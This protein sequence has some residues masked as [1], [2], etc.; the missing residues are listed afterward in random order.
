MLWQIMLPYMIHDL[1]YVYHFQPYSSRIWHV[2]CHTGRQSSQSRFGCQDGSD[3]QHGTAVRFFEGSFLSAMSASSD[4][5]DRTEGR[6]LLLLWLHEKARKCGG[7]FVVFFWGGDV[8]MPIGGGNFK[9]C[10]LEFSTWKLGK[11]YE[12]ILINI[13][14]STTNWFIFVRRFCEENRLNGRVRP[15]V[16]Y[17]LV[18]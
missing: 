9:Y 4:P 10:F 1:F 17:G 3:S 12:D 18:K 15:H 13:F 16:N 7:R 14:R 2:S 6:K 5:N 8:N 11:I